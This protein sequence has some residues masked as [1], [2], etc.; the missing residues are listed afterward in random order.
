MFTLARLVARYLPRA[1]ACVRWKSGR[2]PTILSDELDLGREA[3]N[4]CQL[5]R[6]FENSKAGLC[7][8]GVLGLHLP[9]RIRHGADLRHPVTDMADAADRGTDL[10][11]LAERGVEIFSPRCSATAFSR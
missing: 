10:K 11:L 8:A 4:A 3:A 2:L 7:A 9:Q 5:R 6:N 1:G